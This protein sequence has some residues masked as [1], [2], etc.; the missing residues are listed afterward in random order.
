[1]QGHHIMEGRWLR[2]PSVVDD[3]ARFWFKGEGFRKQYTWWAAFALWQR[4]LVSHAQ[5][6]DGITGELFA[7]LDAHYHDWIRTHYSTKAGCMFT[8]CHA[9]GE[10]NSAGLDGCR[11]T[12]NAAMHGEAI[13]L[14]A[15][16]SAMGNFSRAAYFATEAERWRAVLTRKLW[17]EKLGFFVNEAQPAPPSMHAELRRYHA[18]K[19]GREVQ[20]Y[21]GCLACHRPRKCPPERGWPIGKRVPVRELMGLSSP[22]YFGAVP[23]DDPKTSAKYASAFRQ[24]EDAEGF[25]AAWGPRTTERRSSCYNFSNSAQCNWNGGSWRSVLGVFDRSARCRCL[26]ALTCSPALLI[27]CASLPSSSQLLSLLSLCLLY[28]QPLRPRRRVPL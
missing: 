9:D 19:R 8:S 18:M 22:W 16:A 21:L 5:P 17:D 20:T 28:L 14:G 12:I 23:S 6:S 2:D 3:Y 15:I 4:S 26:L 7:E 11:P 27:H 25:G 10:E 24:L 13:A 1:M